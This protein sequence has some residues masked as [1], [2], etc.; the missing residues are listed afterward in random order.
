MEVDYLCFPILLQ[1]NQSRSFNSHRILIL[2]TYSGNLIQTKRIVKMWSAC[3]NYVINLYENII[4]SSCLTRGIF[5]SEWRKSNVVSL[6]KN[7]DK[8]YR[9]AANM[10]QSFWTP[11]LS[12]SCFPIFYKTISCKKIS[13]V[14]NL[15]TV[16]TKS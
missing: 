1:T 9:L 14:L 4:F 10:Q 15:L 2:E 8:N 7:N 11:Y 3:S 6:H 12:T 16:L 5:P 13:L